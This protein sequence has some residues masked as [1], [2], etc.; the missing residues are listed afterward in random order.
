MF[1]DYGRSYGYQSMLAQIQI[2]TIKAEL[3]RD[4]QIAAQLEKLLTKDAISQTELEIA[5][6]KVIWGEKQLK[7]A[8]KNLVAISSQF[9]AMK[10]MAKHFAGVE[11]PRDELYEVFR[12]GWQ[13]G[14]DKGRMRLML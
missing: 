8:E 12:K 1:V 14:C 3:E 6:L 11:V 10:K 2:E 7:V 9:E 13:A 4:R 5:Q